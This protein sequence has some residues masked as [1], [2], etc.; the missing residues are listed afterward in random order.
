MKG[1][2]AYSFEPSKTL[3]R[4]ILIFLSGSNPTPNINLIL[5]ILLKKDKNFKK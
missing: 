2:I 3:A 1:L 5:N 4:C